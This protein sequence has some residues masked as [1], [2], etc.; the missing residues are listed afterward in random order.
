MVLELEEEGGSKAAAS[1]A[2]A[3]EDAGASG[4]PE[5]P[6]ETSGDHASGI[7]HVERV[8]RTGANAGAATTG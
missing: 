2:G 3:P 1:S 8:S 5:E 6:A 4:A 7:A